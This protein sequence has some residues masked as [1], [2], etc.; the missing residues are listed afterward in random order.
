MTTNTCNN[1]FSTSDYQR[2]GKDKFGNEIYL[3]F[4][5]RARSWYLTIGS[6]F[7]AR[8]DKRFLTIES[9]GKQELR[10]NLP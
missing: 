5:G 3:W 1:G 2:D 6:D 4:N 9:Q 7:Q 10:I 8:N